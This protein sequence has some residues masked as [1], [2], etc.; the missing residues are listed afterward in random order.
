ME[1]KV[2]LK[3]RGKFIDG[4]M[5]LRMFC[6]NDSGFVCMYL[7]WKKLGN[8]YKKYLFLR[9]QHCVINV[10]QYYYYNF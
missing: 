5:F 6:L 4:L 7:R 3:Q 9:L 2:F 10:T 1:S 8:K